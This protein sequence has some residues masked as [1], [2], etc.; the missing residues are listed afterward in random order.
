MDGINN[1]HEHSLSFPVSRGLRD[2][3]RREKNERKEREISTGL[4]AFFF[5]AADQI[6]CRNR[7]VFKPGLF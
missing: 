5:V 4:H 6:C 1:L 2:L 3:S 7:R